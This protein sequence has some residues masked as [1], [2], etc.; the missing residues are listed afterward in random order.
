MGGNLSMSKLP[1]QVGNSLPLQPIVTRNLLPVNFQQEEF[2]KAFIHA[3][4]SIAGYAF[5][6]T[7]VD[8]DRI[9]VEFKS[10]SDHGTVA[11]P[12]LAAQLKCTWTHSLKG[13]EV[14]Y[15]LKVDNYNNLIKKYHVPRILILVTVPENLNGCLSQSETELI[16]KDCAYWVSLKSL[17]KTNNDTTVRIK[18][19]RN[20]VFNADSLHKIMD[21]IGNEEDI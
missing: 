3:I 10:K 11:S 5:E 12:Q 1:H 8:I 4:A 2:S 13:N 9:D 7:A 19:P 20:Q 18:I 21:K 14:I 16:L 15:D 17:P 6:V